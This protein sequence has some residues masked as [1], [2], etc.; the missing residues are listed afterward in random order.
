MVH[1]S[2]EVKY[3]EGLYVPGRQRGSEPAVVPIGQKLPENKIIKI[4]FIMN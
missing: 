3:D 4:N 1:S 2:R